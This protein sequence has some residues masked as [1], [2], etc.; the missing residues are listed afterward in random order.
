MLA[1]GLVVLLQGGR[2][3]ISG[4]VQQGLQ[5]G[6]HEVPIDSVGLAL[7]ELAEQLDRPE[8]IDGEITQP[9][10]VIG[11]I[12]LISG[13]GIREPGPHPRS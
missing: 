8:V 10:Q 1:A 12:D 2:E 4:A 7:Q 3:D 5:V 11:F 9:D 13:E 6:V